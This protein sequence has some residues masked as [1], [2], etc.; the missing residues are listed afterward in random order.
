[1]AF[2]KAL[3]PGIILTWVVSIIIGSNHS[4]GGFINIQRESIAGHDIYWSWPLF[5]ASTMIAWAIIAMM[6]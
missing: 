2:F 5:I 4:D 6:D 1:M 3:I